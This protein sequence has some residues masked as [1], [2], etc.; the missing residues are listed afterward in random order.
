MTKFIERMMLFFGVSVYCTMDYTPSGDELTI[1][2]TKEDYE[3]D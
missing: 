2:I 1:K 3:T